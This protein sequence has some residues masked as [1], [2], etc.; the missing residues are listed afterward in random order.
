MAV[1]GIGTVDNPF[2]VHSYNEFISLSEHAPI[3]GT[4]A[5]YI[6]WFDTPNQV[7]DC[8]SY[9][10]E[11][12]WGA[13]TDNAGTTGSV[14]YYIDLNGCTIKNF[15][16]NDGATMFQGHYYS[17]NGNRGTIVIS[18]G[19]LRNI[20]MG[21][22]TSKLF[23]AYVEWHDVSISINVA[24]TTVIPFGHT[25]LNTESPKMDNC[26]IY[27]VASTLTT[28]LMRKVDLSDTDIELHVTD[29][30]RI[31]IFPDC[32]F[33][34]CRVQGKI[35][36]TSED[37]EGSNRGVVLGVLSSN[38]NASPTQWTNCVFDVDLTE[39]NT[40]SSFQPLDVIYSFSTGINTNVICKSHYPT[41][42]TPP[43]AWN[44]MTHDEIRNGTYLNSKGFTVVEV[45]DGD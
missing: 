18:N 23:G 17:V 40:P 21:S 19:F 36:G 10:S 27:L 2:V 12:K 16:I 45:V 41:G 31:K 13:F 5:V 20:F 34:D 30:N 39:I 42:K 38:Y 32:S 1:T 35:S 24:G 4:G 43:S 6:K 37:A 29:Q 28:H 44:Y 14:T 8:N 33:T 9:G 3:S 7:L 26:A 15:L 22:A 25:D 11:F